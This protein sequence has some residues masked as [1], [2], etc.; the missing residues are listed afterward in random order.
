MN[1]DSK[2][3]PKVIQIGS[4]INISNVDPL[5]IDSYEEVLKIFEDGKKVRVVGST[6]MNNTSSRS[7]A[8]FTIHYK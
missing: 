7:H 5:P 6:K 8:I 4:A 1:P 3:E 2:K